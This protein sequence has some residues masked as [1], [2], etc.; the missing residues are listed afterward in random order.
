MTM[1]GLHFV[2]PISGPN[3]PDNLKTQIV[4]RYATWTSR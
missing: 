3:G 4:F 2:H 1:L